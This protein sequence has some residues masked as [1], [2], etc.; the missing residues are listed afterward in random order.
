MTSPA[1]TSQGQES[2]PARGARPQDRGR[3]A[4]AEELVRKHTDRAKR[5]SPEE[6]KAEREAF[7]ERMRK[8]MEERRRRREERRSRRRDDDEDDEDGGN[9][10]GQRRPATGPGSAVVSAPR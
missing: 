2:S 4:R 7:A 9:R 10:R 1:I 6:R 5:R 3:G 8:R